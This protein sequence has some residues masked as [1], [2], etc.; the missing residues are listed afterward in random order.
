[1]NKIRAYRLQQEEGLDTVEANEH[2]GF[3]PDLREYGIGAQIMVDLGIRQVRL[4]TNNPRKVVALEGYSLKIVERV[5]L[6]VEPNELN[7]RYLDTKRR[8]MGHILDE[9]SE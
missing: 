9:P 2:L 6:V 4:M 1:V 8:K 5:P 3:E 7:A